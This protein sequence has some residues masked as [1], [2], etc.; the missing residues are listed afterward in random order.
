LYFIDGEFTMGVDMKRNAAVFL[1]A[2][3]VG[4]QMAHGQQLDTV[5]SAVNAA[6]HW[7]VLAD[8]NDG[9]ATWDQAAPSF[10][11]AI[12]KGGWSQALEQARQPFG[13]VKSRKVVSSEVRH[14]LPGAPD[15]ECV[16]IQ[17]DTQFEHKTH[18]VETVVPM[19]DQAGNWK[20]SG[21]F[22]K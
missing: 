3:I 13:A 17:Y 1:L 10:Q 22:V 15:G 21:Y 19:R 14:A 9:A 7:L 20:V 6:N 18:A 11:A 4:S 8:A 16:V 2:A 12:A 5:G